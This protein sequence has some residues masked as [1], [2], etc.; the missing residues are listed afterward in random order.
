MR[1]SE[2][3]RS[4][5]P[6]EIAELV[7]A[8]MMGAVTLVLLVACAN[9]ANLMVVRSSGRQREFCVRAALGAGRGQLV[10]QLLTECVALGLAAAPLGLAIAYLGVRLLDHAVPAGQVPSYLH[11]EISGRVIAYT[12]V[13]SALTGLIFGLAPALQA[14][15]LNLQE[16]LQ[17]GARGS[18]QSRPSSSLR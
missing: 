10:K 18:G 12:M 5:T 14:G 9:V 1:G 7:L 11:W 13:V 15:R 6:E 2:A 3:E 17:D 16:M 8:T 4:F